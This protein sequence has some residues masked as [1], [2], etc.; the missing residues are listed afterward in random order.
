MGS[1]EIVDVMLNGNLIQGRVR[2]NY[3]GRYDGVQVNAH[4]YDSKG[5]VRF[6]EVNGR[7]ESI[8]R[9]FIGKDELASNSNQSAFKA[10]IEGDA[11]RVRLRASIIQEHK[12]VDY[13]SLIIDV[14]S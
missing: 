3:N 1:I 9:L 4:V 12:E 2:V 14:Y 11:E 13:H 5:I 10:L 6:I 8:Y 7:K